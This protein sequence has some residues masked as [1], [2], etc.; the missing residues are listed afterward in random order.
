MRWTIRREDAV[1]GIGERYGCYVG[2]KCDGWFKL[3]L[4]IDARQ[5][6]PA[7]A[8]DSANPVVT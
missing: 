1:S 3:V 2:S 6:V 7:S 5:K 8:D 4:A